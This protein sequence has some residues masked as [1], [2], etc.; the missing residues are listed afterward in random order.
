MATELQKRKW[1]NLFKMLDF[2]GDGV[3]EKADIETMAIQIAGMRGFSPGSPQHEELHGSFMGFW[4]GVEEL[5]DTD[6]DDKVSLAEWLA[7][8]TK[9]TE[10]PQMYQS[11]NKPLSE[12]IFGLLDED[13]DGQI[14]IDEYRQF[15][16]MMRMSEAFA[17]EMFSKLDLN[18][19]D[20]ISMEGLL[21]LT[22]QFFVGDDPNAPGNLFF[23]PI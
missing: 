16:K 4:S 1:P 18:Q 23:G 2:N 22:E 8:W 19:D 21:T 17:D 5:A 10:S 3:V 11:V 13:G 14:T 20:G 15:Y 7:Y 12:F 9:V 6:K